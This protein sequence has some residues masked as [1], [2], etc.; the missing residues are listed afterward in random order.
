MTEEQLGNVMIGFA[1]QNPGQVVGLICKDG[2]LRIGLIN[3]VVGEEDWFYKP[4][5]V[6]LE[7]SSESIGAD[8]SSDPGGTRT[9]N[10][11]IKSPLQHMRPLEVGHK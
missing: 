1:E 2:R 9:L 7:E 6:P 8:K 11:L 5:L 4:V 10:Q 3:W